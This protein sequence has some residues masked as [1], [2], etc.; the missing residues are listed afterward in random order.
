MALNPGTII[1]GYEIIETIGTGAMSTVYLAKKDG[2]SYALKELKSE[3]SS[4]E[5]KKLLINVFHRE[6]D[7]LFIY[8]HPGIPKFY[9]NF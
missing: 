2:N 1:E 6:A 9:K 8:F 5:E 4:P 3:I 7:I